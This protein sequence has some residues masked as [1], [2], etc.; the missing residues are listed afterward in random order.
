M[1]VGD[2]ISDFFRSGG[3]GDHSHLDFQVL[4]NPGDIFSIPDDLD[5]MDHNLFFVGSSSTKQLADRRIF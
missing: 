1:K 4:D 3:H 5:S 2:D